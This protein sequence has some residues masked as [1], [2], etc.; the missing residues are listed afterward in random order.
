[1]EVSADSAARRRDVVEYVRDEPL[2]ALAIAA[3]AGFVLG[4]GVNRRIGLTMLTIVGRIALSGVATSLI[5]GIMSGSNDHLRQDSAG[6]AGGRHGN[7]KTEG[8][9]FQKSG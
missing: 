6:P 9:D 2:T 1:M 8:T 3:M 5:A 7:G 4:G